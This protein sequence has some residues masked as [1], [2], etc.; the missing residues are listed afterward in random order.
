ML[1]SIKQF[2]LNIHVLNLTHIIL[3]S[4]HNTKRDRERERGSAM[5]VIVGEA[6]FAFSWFQLLQNFQK[7]VQ[8]ELC[9]DVSG[10]TGLRSGNNWNPPC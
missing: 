5:L 3:E 1:G 7:G 9:C 6:H 4:H 10:T 8:G 2:P